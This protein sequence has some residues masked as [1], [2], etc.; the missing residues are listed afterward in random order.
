MPI[1]TYFEDI[2]A[3]VNTGKSLTEFH[4]KAKIVGVAEYKSQQTGKTS[5]KITFN[6]EGVDFG[7]YM[8]L[9]DK[10]LQITLG[11]LL[12]VLIAAVGED[13]AKSLFEKLADDEDV[14]SETELAIALAQKVNAKLKQNEVFAQ[15]DRVKNGEFWDVKWKIGADPATVDATN[16]PPADGQTGELMNS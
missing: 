10:S 16:N 15:V 9:K 3:N 5:I 11:R 1:K 13:K 14:N 6:A 4:G 7:A 8:G 12:R 2:M